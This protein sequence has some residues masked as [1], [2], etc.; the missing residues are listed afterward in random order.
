MLSEQVLIRVKRSIIVEAPVIIYKCKRTA[1]CYITI[2]ISI[3]CLNKNE[4]RL[5]GVHL[6]Q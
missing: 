1:F 6:K 4:L 3:A 5:F 2:K